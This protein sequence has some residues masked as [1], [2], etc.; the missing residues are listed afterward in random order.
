MCIYRN[1]LEFNK[2]WNVVTFLV[3]HS[4]VAGSRSTVMGRKRAMHCR[5]SPVRVMEEEEEEGEGHS[6]DEVK[7]A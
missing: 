2:N 6:L 4:A 1:N 7:R 3:T 5:K